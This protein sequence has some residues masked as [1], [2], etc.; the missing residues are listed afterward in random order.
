[1]KNR[2]EKL[3]IYNEIDRE[4]FNPE[5]PTNPMLFID[6]DKQKVVI[7]PGVPYVSTS[8]NEIFERR[9]LLN[10]KEHLN[11]IN[12]FIAAPIDDKEQSI[13]E[14]KKEESYIRCIYDAY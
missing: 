9:I 8:Q 2:K 3:G 10:Q 1:M 12:P 6:N 13:Y 4:W 5:K 14:G 7:N 11:K